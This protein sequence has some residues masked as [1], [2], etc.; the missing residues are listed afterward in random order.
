MG[1]LHRELFASVFLPSSF[2]FLLLVELVSLL[3]HLSYSVPSFLTCSQAREGSCS[4]WW[5]GPQVHIRQFCLLHL[6]CAVQAYY[7]AVRV[8]CKGTI[9]LLHKPGT[10]CVGKVSVQHCIWLTCSYL[11][12]TDYILDV[13]VSKY[14]KFGQLHLEILILLYLVHMSR[15]AKLGRKAQEKMQKEPFPHPPK[16]QNS[17]K[18]VSHHLPLL[19]VGYLRCI[20]LRRVS[21]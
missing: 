15:E 2:A 19:F 3:I 14:S 21:V 8:V 13:K 16:H 17:P 5:F 6:L 20:Q 18:E 7:N 1:G 9:C 12:V 11:Y 10:N 4:Q